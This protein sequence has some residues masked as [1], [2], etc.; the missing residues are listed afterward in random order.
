MFDSPA[1]V[2]HQRQRGKSDD[3]VYQSLAAQIDLSLQ[4]LPARFRTRGVHLTTR[5]AHKVSQDDVPL[6]FLSPN[7][8]FPAPYL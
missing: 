3:R 8:P 2:I 7:I 4:W 5:A 6:N 1:H